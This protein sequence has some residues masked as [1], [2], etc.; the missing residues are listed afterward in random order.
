[1]GGPTLAGPYVKAKKA[2]LAQACDRIFSGDFIAEV[3]VKQAALSWVPQA[4]RF[5]S[6]AD[7]ASPDGSAGEQ[8]A[9]DTEPDADDV[10]SADESVAEAIEEA[11]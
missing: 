11:A 1:M 6:P 3:E 2:E 7:E 10:P 8:P 9:A 4:M 5:A